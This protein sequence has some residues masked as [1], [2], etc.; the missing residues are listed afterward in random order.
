M[1]LV[2]IL[3]VSNPVRPIK[4]AEIKATGKLLIP[5]ADGKKPYKCVIVFTQTEISFE[6]DK[7]IFQSFNLFDTPKQAAI[8]VSTAEVKR[9][10]LQGNRVII[11]PEDSL[12]NRYRNLLNHV[13]LITWMKEWERLVFVFII[14]GNSTR[15]IGNNAL[16]LIDLIN[17]RNDPECDECGFVKFY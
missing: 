3:A 1:V 12:Y 5:T 2:I 10:T 17:E 9:I 7:K 4:T 11:F 16:K 8:K 14:N 13:C 6:C 15:N